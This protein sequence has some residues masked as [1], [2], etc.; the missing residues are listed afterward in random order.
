MGYATKVVL[1]ICKEKGSSPYL[2]ITLRS[3]EPAEC[4][5]ILPDL[6]GKDSLLAL[7]DTSYHPISYITSLPPPLLFSSTPNCLPFE[8]IDNIL[9]E[10][11]KK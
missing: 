1:L 10:K 11:E 9:P 5:D 7:L 6:K 4:Q 8:R 2:G 3:A